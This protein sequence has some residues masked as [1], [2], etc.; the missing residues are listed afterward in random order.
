MLLLVLFKEAHFSV[1]GGICGDSQ[2]HKGLSTSDKRKD[3]SILSS[4]AQK[5]GQK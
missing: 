1:N 2:I 5:R 4:K 3:I